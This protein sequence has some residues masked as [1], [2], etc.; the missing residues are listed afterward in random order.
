[1]REIQLIPAVFFVI[2]L[3]FFLLLYLPSKKKY[4]AYINALDK[5]IFPLKDFMPIGFAFM[6]KLH[7]GYNNK[8]DRDMRKK[9][10]E[11]HEED[12]NEFY[13]RA[14]WA[15]AASYLWIG[16][17]LTA[18]FYLATSELM[19]FGLGLFVTGVMVYTVPS[20]I[21]KKVEK[22]HLKVALDLPDYISKI[23]ILTSAGL[24]LRAAMKKVS[25]EMSLPSPLY[26]LMGQA[27]HNIDNGMNENI[28]LDKI[29]YRCNM[30]EMRRLIAVIEQNLQR[31]GSDVTIAMQAI[32]DEMWNNRKAKA[33]QI[34]AE[35][36]TKMLF[37]MMLMMLS[38]IVMTMVP[39]ILGMGI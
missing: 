14:Y 16:L 1:M 18:L 36:E 21:N 6:E 30:P 24:T 19:Y 8:L 5:E 4:E 27:M 3:V 13:L 31:G 33:Q 20:D 17:L 15:A 23:I 37:P 7:Y 10:L 26:Q 29:V 32:G 12:F 38:V 11:L 28:A 35:A 25:E 39:A 22:L 34:A 2:V 9:L